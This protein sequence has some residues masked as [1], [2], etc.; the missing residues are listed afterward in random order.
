ARAAELGLHLVRAHT[1]GTDPGYVRMIR[2]LI[3]ERI[4]ATP[5][6]HALGELGPGHDVCAPD[7]CL[8]VR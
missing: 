8:P 6:R 7:C 2:E 3:V 4:H 5:A 1:V